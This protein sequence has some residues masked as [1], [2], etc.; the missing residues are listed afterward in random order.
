[1]VPIAAFLAI[2]WK[3]VPNR[4]VKFDENLKYDRTKTIARQ[5]ASF[6]LALTS[7][8][9]SLLFSVAKVSPASFNLSIL[10]VC[11]RFHVCE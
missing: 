9:M 11:C 1:M 6:G 8:F 2:I 10:N 7:K 5:I 3:P 4:T